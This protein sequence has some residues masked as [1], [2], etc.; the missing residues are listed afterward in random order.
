LNFWENR[1]DRTMPTVLECV[2]L[3]RRRGSR[4][5]HKIFGIVGQLFV[6]W[7]NATLLNRLDALFGV[8]LPVVDHG[9]AQI[10]E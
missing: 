9:A 7:A 8:V 2:Y 10:A 6:G 3:V 4:L 5:V 1:L